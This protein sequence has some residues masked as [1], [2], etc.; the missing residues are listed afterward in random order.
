MHT[1]GFMLPY[2]SMAGVISLNDA[3]LRRDENLVEPLSRMDNTPIYLQLPPPLLREG[4]NSLLIRVSGLVPFRPGLPAPVVGE[5][6]KISALYQDEYW[7]RR[8]LQL[9]GLTVAATLSGF[10]PRHLVD[11]E[12][13]SCLRLVWYRV[14]DVGRIY[15]Q[16]CCAKSVAV[17]QHGLV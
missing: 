9:I 17:Q 12:K 1:L 5:P 14:S 11:A 4:D 16:Q 15:L 7:Q 8:D 13:R 10:F 2:I 3:E 6:T